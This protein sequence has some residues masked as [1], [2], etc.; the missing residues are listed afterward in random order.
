[1]SPLLPLAFIPIAAASIL[2]SVH[3]LDKQTAEQCITHDWPAD[4][5]ALHVNWCRTAGY[6]VQALHTDHS[7]Q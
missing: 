1:M 3:T 2:F 7:V 5:H 4:S 6:A